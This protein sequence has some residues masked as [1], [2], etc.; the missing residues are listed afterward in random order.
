MKHCH[1]NSK[2]LCSDMQCLLWSHGI[3]VRTNNKRTTPPGRPGCSPCCINHRTIL[4]WFFENNSWGEELGVPWLPEHENGST[5]GLQ[6]WTQWNQVEMRPAT[7]RRTCVIWR[8]L[9]RWSCSCR[10]RWCSAWSCTTRSSTPRRV[11]LAG[12]YSPRSLLPPWCVVPGVYPL[13]WTCSPGVRTG[14]YGWSCTL[15]HRTCSHPCCPWGSGCT[16][17]VVVAAP[18]AGVSPGCWRRPGAAGCTCTWSRSPR[19]ARARC[20][21]PA[22]RSGWRSGPRGTCCPLGGGGGGDGAPTDP[23][24]HCRQPDHSFSLPL[25][26][27]NRR[28]IQVCLR[29]WWWLF[30]QSPAKKKK[31]R[32]F[33]YAQF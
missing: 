1:G 2:A 9:P 24:A 33:T 25:A 13:G 27:S 29:W 17:R 10:E 20:P 28:I 16:C 18:V 12:W 32:N 26:R 7:K 6:K 15:I 11:L 30:T 23:W 3:L 5:S 19:R 14:A 31:M 22:D 21:T 4:N 8:A